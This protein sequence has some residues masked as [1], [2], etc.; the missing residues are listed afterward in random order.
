MK[1][2]PFNVDNDAI[3]KQYNYS[4]SKNRRVVENA[5]GHLKARFRRIGKGVDNKLKNV[6]TIIKAC[7]VLH[8]FVNEN[9]DSINRQWLKEVK[10]K[11]QPRH[12][13]ILIENKNG[14]E[15]RQAIASCIGMFSFIC[16]S[17]LMYK[18]TKNYF[19]ITKMK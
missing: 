2:Y 17:F 7:C 18:H 1:P 14:E 6:N 5:F 15:I 4:F 11:Q 12:E 8:N 9:N 19:L 3:K 13:T 10:T 16:N